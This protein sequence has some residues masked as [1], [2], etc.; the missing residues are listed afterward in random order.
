MLRPP[1]N[2]HGIKKRLYCADSPR[3][4][5]SSPPDTTTEFDEYTPKPLLVTAYR[6]PSKTNLWANVVLEL[7]LRFM[8]VA[9][10]SLKTTGAAFHV[11][12]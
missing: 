12:L 7:N 9:T 1:V 4:N 2:V 3:K 10:V 11:P 5:V 6:P 8:F